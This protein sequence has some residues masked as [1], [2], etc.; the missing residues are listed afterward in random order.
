LYQSESL[1]A[2]TP[3]LS[4]TTLWPQMTMKIESKSKVISN[5]FVSIKTFAFQFS[6]LNFELKQRKTDDKHQL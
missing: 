3:T 5:S 4:A 2:S 6:A 1:C